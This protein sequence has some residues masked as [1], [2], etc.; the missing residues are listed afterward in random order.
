[1]KIHMLYSVTTVPGLPLE[2]EHYPAG[3]DVPEIDVSEADAAWLIAH[4]YAE[5]V[6]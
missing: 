3:V 2:Q 4:G 1:M 6:D 5:A